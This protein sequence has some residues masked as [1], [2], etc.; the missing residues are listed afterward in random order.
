MLTALLILSATAPVRAREPISGDAARAMAVEYVAAQLNATVAS[1]TV[2]NEGLVGGPDGTAT[3]YYYV[4][5]MDSET[6]I[7]YAWV[8]LATGQR[9]DLRAF[10]DL[11]REAEAQRGKLNPFV[12]RRLAELSTSETMTVALVLAVPGV[13]NVGEQL[14]QIDP[15]VQLDAGVPSSGDSRINDE[16]QLRLRALRMAL[17]ASVTESVASEARSRGLRVDFASRLVP[18]LFVSGNAAQIR[19]IAEVA[20]VTS[21]LASLPTTLTQSNRTKLTTPT[22]VAGT[23]QRAGHRRVRQNSPL[24]NTTTSTGRTSTSPPYPTAART[25][26]RPGGSPDMPTRLGLWE[27]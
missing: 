19:A 4:K 18:M 11:A 13:E 15:T 21:V 16:V 25:T 10:E 17:I 24:W 7:A 1:V 5:A 12:E 6:N 22:P 2:L 27:R 3:S 20:R 14:R 9:L 26:T 23:A 8:E